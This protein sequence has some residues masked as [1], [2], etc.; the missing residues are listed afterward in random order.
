[1]CIS[2][3]NSSKILY[4]SRTLNKNSTTSTDV[5]TNHTRN[6][7]RTFLS[8]SPP[9]EHHCVQQNVTFCDKYNTEVC[10]LSTNTND[11]CTTSNK[12]KKIQIYTL[13]LNIMVII[14]IEN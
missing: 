3:S 14:K 6:I 1:M 9:S 11:V 2:S 13:I 7:T 10:T 12:N 5:S 4:K 8:A